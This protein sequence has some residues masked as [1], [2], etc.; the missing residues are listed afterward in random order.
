MEKHR[1]PH[2]FTFQNHEIRTVKKDASIWFVNVD[3]CQALG[4]ADSREALDYLYP[5]KIDVVEGQDINDPNEFL[6][7]IVSESGMKKILHHSGNPELTKSRQ[8]TRP[9]YLV[10]EDDVVREQAPATTPEQPQP[11]RLKP[12]PGMKP[13]VPVPL[14]CT[15]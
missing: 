14:P 10:Y 9:K 7:S 2:T 1:H 8:I 3:V 4:I 11:A 6:L 15:L 13:V 5:K 12:P